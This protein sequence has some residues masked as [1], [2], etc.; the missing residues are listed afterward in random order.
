MAVLLL[1]VDRG[2][3]L[4]HLLQFRRIEDFAGPCRPPHF[5]RQRERGAAVAV[6]HADQRLARLG[7]ERKRLAFDRL[8]AREQ[9]LERIRSERLEHQ[10]AGPRQQRRDQ[11]ERRIFGGGANEHDGAVLHHRQETILLRPVEAVDLVD[12]KQRPLPGLAPR[13]RRVEH[14][15]E[16]GH[17]GKNRRDLLE[18]KLGRPRQEA[19]D[20]GL[21]G[22]GRAPEHE[23]A[24][25]AGVEQARE[26][27]IGPEQMVL[28][29][30]LGKLGRPQ[31]VRERTRS[32]ALEPGGREQA[33]SPALGG[34][35]HPRS[36]TDICWPPRM[37]VMLQRRLG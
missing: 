1:V 36:S 22:A 35:L 3:A 19:R 31:L 2:A 10:D 4:H 25:R 14:L 28:A 17:A 37:M 13:A 15:L 21:A 34:C 12:E 11:L 20:R 24:E 9:P 32:V 8:G 7:I 29:H 30:H 23:R 27:T 5:F 26:R 6:G 33:R 18:V 16:I